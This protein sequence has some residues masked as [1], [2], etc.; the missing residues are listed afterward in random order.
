MNPSAAASSAPL[1][2]PSPRLGASLLL[3]LG[4]LAACG[5]GDAPAPMAQPQI[6]VTTMA[7]IQAKGGGGGGAPA[8]AP[9]PAPAPSPSPAPAPAAPASAPAAAVNGRLPPNSTV[10]GPAW[11][12]ANISSVNI[13]GFAPDIDYTR[14]QN[15]TEGGIPVGSTRAAT[16]LVYNTSKKTALTI[17]DI[18]MTGAN[19]GDFSIDAQTLATIESTTLPA[20]KSAVEAIPITFKPG[21]PGPRSANVVFTSAAG[22]V[23]VGVSG[24]GLPTQPVLS[25]A[26]GALAFLPGSAPATLIIQNTGGV[27]L[28]L[29]S[30][31]IGGTNP[32]DFFLTSG[33]RSGNCFAGVLIAPLSFCFIG[34][35]VAAGAAP[36]ASADLL[37]VSNDPAHPTIDVPLSIVAPPAP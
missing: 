3:T 6:A 37:L 29:R 5:G 18:H 21:A 9:T 15:M 8:P 36:P 22:V 33:A 1:P 11:A 35:G 14:I 10:D 12:F 16:E 31:S 17:T 30:F 28:Q 32:A 27:S 26:N 4:G 23:Q 24:V 7:T 20:N 2:L 13:T 25:G 19:P 34:V